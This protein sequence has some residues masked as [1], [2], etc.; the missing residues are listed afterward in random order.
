MCRRENWMGI[1]LIGKIGSCTA[2]S[3]VGKGSAGWKAM[4]LALNVFILAY[5][6]V[7]A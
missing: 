3:I 2:A 6:R 1:L 4:W 7:V 5:F